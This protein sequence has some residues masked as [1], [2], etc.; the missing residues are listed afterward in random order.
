MTEPR[1]QLS[2]PAGVT[3]TVAAWGAT[4][5]GLS[6]PDRDGHVRDVV[7]GFDAA[8]A[9]E[10]NPTLYFGSTIGR[11]AN[12]TAGARFVLDG[13][14][15]LLFANDGPN[16]LHGGTL[17]S[18]DRVAWE[19]V[20]LPGAGEGVAFRLVS[21]DGEEGY[22][23]RL[24]V[25]VA[26]V[27]RADGELVID[28]AAVADRRTPVNLTNHAYFNL[29]GAG[30]RTILDHELT[31]DADR[32][33][34]IGEGLIPTGAI[35]PVEGTPFDLRRPTL[36]ARPVAALEGSPAR[37]LDHNLVLRA[38]RDPSAP[39]ARLHHPAS[40]RTLELRTDAPCLQVYSGNFLTTT[41]GKDGQVYEHRSGLCLE[42][43][44]PPDAIH[45]PAFDALGG[46]IVVEPGETWRRRISF[47]LTRG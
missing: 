34:P 21:P 47:R 20:P 2:S 36:L 7:L 9:Y 32:Y 12:R 1:I 19:T 29:A 38:D 41:H 6:G 28:L 17:R 5:V 14:E 10:A 44:S 18:F 40:G 15:H 26:Y 43:Q 13:V 42:P 30:A 31:V 8:A 46:S 33:T 16:H 27:L 11:V 39:A 25:T 4:L 22:P 35:E 37:G 23:G 45:H 3:A 24:E